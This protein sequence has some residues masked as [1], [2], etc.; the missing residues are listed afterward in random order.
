MK[1]KLHF[2]TAI[3]LLSFN[4]KATEGLIYSFT[5]KKSAQVRETCKIKGKTKTSKIK[6]ILRRDDQNN[7][8]L[9]MKAW[10]NICRSKSKKVSISL[11]LPLSE[12]AVDFQKLATLANFEE[13]KIN[14]LPD[15]Q[16]RN[17]D[18]QLTIKKSSEELILIKGNGINGQGYEYRWNRGGKTVHGPI[19]IYVALDPNKIENIDGYKGDMTPFI[20]LDITEKVK[21]GFLNI[22]IEVEGMLRKVEQL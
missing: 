6:F 14:S 1:I 4:A 3:F 8:L 13:L 7:D 2:I 18:F 20:Y 21:L 15:I 16:D 5:A 11:D 10:A 17:G 19:T 9:V 22:K 12:K